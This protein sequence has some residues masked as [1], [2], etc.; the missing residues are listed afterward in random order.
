LA[1]GG[2]D[3]GKRH[4]LQ[5]LE[6]PKG[7]GYRTDAR[8]HTRSGAQRS[9]DLREHRLYL[10]EDDRQANTE[11]VDIFKWIETDLKTA[12][13]PDEMLKPIALA[14]ELV[15]SQWFNRLRASNES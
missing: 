10:S 2:S 4:D 12:E 13:T 9:V 7:E 1:S 8:R 6:G 5:F 3:G 14:K 15:D 11:A